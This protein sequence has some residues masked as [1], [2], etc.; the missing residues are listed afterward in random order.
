M[1]NSHLLHNVLVTHWHCQRHQT[2]SARTK[3]I[4]VRRPEAGGQ[5]LQNGE[6]LIPLVVH[7]T[8]LVSLDL[9]RSGSR[10]GCDRPAFH[11]PPFF[12]VDRTRL[13]VEITLNCVAE[14]CV[15][16]IV[17]GYTAGAFQCFHK[18]QRDRLKTKDLAIVVVCLSQE[19]R[20]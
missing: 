19:K 4:D 11:A 20:Q 17:E 3:T 13:D 8:S 9:C 6:I 16:D 1:D 15:N 5:Q 7:G 2:P 10:N 14:A 12:F 18:V